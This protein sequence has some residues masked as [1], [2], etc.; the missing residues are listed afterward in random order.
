MQS[1]NK[2]PIKYFSGPIIPDQA[3]Y[4]V[5]CLQIDV[6]AEKTTGELYK[7][8]LS[9]FEKQSTAE[10]YSGMWQNKTVSLQTATSVLINPSQS[11]L[12][13]VVDEFSGIHT[14]WLKTQVRSQLKLFPQTLYDLCLMSL[15]TAVNKFFFK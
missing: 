9:E 5:R 11:A 8:S 10:E 15:E 14:A 3:A 6:S 7:Q 1:G 12:Y 13:G 2:R 4:T